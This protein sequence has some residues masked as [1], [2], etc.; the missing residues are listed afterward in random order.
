VESKSKLLAVGCLFACISL[1][2]A[3]PALSQRV[4]FNGIRVRFSK[5]GADRRLIE[6]SGS[7]IFDDTARKVIVESVKP[8]QIGYDDI[9][10]VVFDRVNRIQERSAAKEIGYGTVTD[11]I[12]TAGPLGKV[13]KRTPEVYSRVRP[14]STLTNFWME[15]E[16]K[17]PGG[18]LQPALIE[19][20]QQ[21]ST[22]VVAKA[23][24][25]FGK[26]VHM[27]DSLQI[28][29]EIGKKT[30]K[31]A[32]AKHQVTVDRR[33]HPIPEIRPDKA[34]VVVACPAVYIPGSVA[35]QFKLHAND[36]VIAVNKIGTY[37]FAYLDPGE[38][39]FASQAG[40]LG[41]NAN[42]FKMI[43][44]AGGDYYFF[45]NVLEGYSTGRYSTGLSRQAK[46]IVMYEVQ[47]SYYSDW[48]RKAP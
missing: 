15:I 10:Q 7:L 22:Q 35:W 21:D 32:K 33:N 44:E 9:A 40:F 13:I 27:P 28:G 3:Q 20:R 48:K 16:I 12:G 43:L 17:M 18:S 8:L 4:V 37:S 23:Q 39:V 41:A 46:E 1:I 31:D 38:Y 5:S 24:Q 34:L 19:L 26:D 25:I 30:L 29:H 6:S 2:L 42:G 36:S 14:L 45:Q 11:I 47:G